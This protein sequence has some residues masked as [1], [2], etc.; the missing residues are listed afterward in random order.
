M[1]F[2]SV[3]VLRFVFTSF[4]F[5]YLK[6]T[7]SS[8]YFVAFMGNSSLGFL[9][10]LLLLLKYF[11]PFFLCIYLFLVCFECLFV[12]LPIDEVVRVRRPYE[13]PPFSIGKYR[14]PS[15]TINDLLN[16]CYYLVCRS[17]ARPSGKDCLN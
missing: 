5:F 11:P 7:P 15:E 4:L 9:V 1:L 10:F 13:C 3:F 16:P 8:T 14:K 6:T 17:I 12:G 2:L